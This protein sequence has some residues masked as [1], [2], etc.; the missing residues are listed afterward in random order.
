MT[1]KICLSVPELIQSATEN[2][3]WE[4]EPFFSLLWGWLEDFGLCGILEGAVDPPKLGEGTDAWVIDSGKAPLGRDW[5]SD[6]TLAS[7]VLYFSDQKGAE[8][9]LE[10]LKQTFS[11]LTCSPVELQPD[12]DWNAKWKASF[13]GILISDLWEVCPPWKDPQLTDPSRVIRVNPGAGFGTGTHETTQLCLEALG[14]CGDLSEESVLDFG[15]GSGI[16]SIAAA[17]KK[18]RV[19]GVEIDELAID[20]A[21]ENLKLNLLS[22]EVQFRKEFP[23]DSRFSM[24]VANILRPVL[25]EYAS[26]ILARLSS[27]PRAVLLSGLLEKDLPEILALYQKPLCDQYGLVM[28]TRSLNEW[29]LV[30]FHRK[31]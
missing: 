29:R 27:S 23:S 28:E 1:Y 24:V 26:R 17:K 20:N 16:L 22:D 18:A 13:Q 2:T 14:E 5:V 9:A 7:S 6:E 31:A 11:N 25:V 10:F 15:S 3:Q 21:Y 4:R 12:E 30:Y 8:D 19:V